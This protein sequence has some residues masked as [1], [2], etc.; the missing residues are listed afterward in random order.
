MQGEFFICDS[1]DKLSNLITHI[2]KEWDIHHWLQ[3]QIKNG[4]IRTTRQNAAI[5]AFFRDVAT[6]LNAKGIDYQHFFTRFDFEFTEHSVKD[7]IWKPVQK[8]VLGFEETHKLER[9][10]VSKIYDILNRKLSEHGIFV[11]LGKEALE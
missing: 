11:P 6:E 1:K 3:V 4:K 2:Q 7:H 5:H 8:A 10:Q 9:D